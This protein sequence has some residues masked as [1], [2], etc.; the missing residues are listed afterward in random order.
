MMG[1]AQIV[2][3][4]KV[5]DPGTTL[6]YKGMMFSDI[7]EPCLHLRL[8]QCL[9]DLESGPDGRVSLPHPQQ[10]GSRRFCLC[11]PRNLDPE[12]TPD[13]TPPLSSGYMQR[14]RI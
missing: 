3:D 10:D 1:G 6:N 8:Y 12:L 2:V 5:I 13:A 11:T 4:G 9:L 14:A 7:P